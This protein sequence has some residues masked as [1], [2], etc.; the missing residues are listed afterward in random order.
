MLTV[1]SAL[2]VA[3]GGFEPQTLVA[4]S[5]WVLPGHQETI[6]AIAFSPDGKK[7]ASAGRDKKVKVWSLD[8]GKEL[9]AAS[10]AVQQLTALAWSA[11]GKRLAVGDSGLSV[12]VLAADTGTVLEQIA[13]PEGI[14]QLAWQPDGSAVAVAG[15]NDLGLVYEVPGGKKR[16]EFKG[17]TAQYSADGKWLLAASN[18][19][20]F[21]LIDAKSG[22]PKQSV[23]TEPDVPLTTMTADAKVIASWTP[24]STDVK[25]WSG[26][27]KSLGVLKG[28]ALELGSRKPTVTG[29]AVLRDGK[30][31]LVGGA[32]G[33]VRLFKVGAEA[34]AQRWPADKN[35]S[36]IVSADETWFA[37]IDST[38]I[39]L[40]KV[41]AAN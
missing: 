18:S 39:K 16:F 34:A 37:V 35:Q 1:I 32:D 20:Y 26:D 33:V 17:R 4:G 22:K 5:P 30:R 19:S 9:L 7:L 31:V 11:D 12:Q 27:G 3:A 10:V 21:A 29:V 14:A 8:T 6:T 28:P 13:H 38:V 40:W 2:I 36:L 25:L 23:K 41:P 15:I 24:A